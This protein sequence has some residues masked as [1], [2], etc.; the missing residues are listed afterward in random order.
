MNSRYYLV[1]TYA[2]TEE[3]EIF[4]LRGCRLTVGRARR[5]TAEELAVTFDS[6][7]SRNHCWVQL[8]GARL[9]V[10]RDKARLPLM[11]NGVAQDEF[12]LTPGESFRTASCIFRFTEAEPESALKENRGNSFSVSFEELCKIGQ[13][14]RFYRM[15]QRLFGADCE[16]AIEEFADVIP[17][18]AAMSVVEWKD[19]KFAEKARYRRGSL[20]LT[21]SRLLAERAWSAQEPTYDF[22]N[23][24]DRKKGSA[25]TMI[26]G[27][28]WMIA[29]P[30]PVE[31]LEERRFLLFA[32]G[33][34]PQDLAVYGEQSTAL[35][36]WLAKWLAQYLD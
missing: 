32:G 5:S 10:A 6:A 35:L 1:C 20:R 27:M 2:P 24:A 31:G 25:P 13:L 33:V 18:I 8:E 4:P 36:G 11:V 28:H 7:L 21:P 22:L 16:R 23:H 29:A 12:C 15:H 3:V 14:K 30:I 19:G 17:E 9:R 34:D 26:L